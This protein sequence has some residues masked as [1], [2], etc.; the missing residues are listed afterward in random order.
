M[1]RR[2]FAL[3]ALAAGI[4]LMAAAPKQAPAPK[5]PPPAK[6]PPPLPYAHQAEARKIGGRL[7]HLYR[8]RALTLINDERD[9]KQLKQLEALGYGIGADG[10]PVVFSL[11]L[12]R[13]LDGLAARATRGKPLALLSL[14]RPLSPNS[15]NEPHGRGIAFDVAAYGGYRID[16]RNPR[17]CVRGVLAVVGALRPGAYRL[18]LPKPPGTDPRALL[19]PSR[20]PRAWPFFPAPVPRVIDLLGFRFVAPRVNNGQVTL[21]RRGAVRPWVLRWENERYAPLSAIGSAP[22]RQALRRAR[23][24]GVHIHS[25]FPDALDHLHI[26]LRP[27]P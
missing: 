4:P 15:P 5:P 7:L 14:Y 27:T 10:K 21:T 1:S 25:A 8:A 6:K 20:R 2:R 22:L 11:A 23:R 12:L 24:R 3:L 26:D 9:K 13:T 16:S 19:P 17:A 18:G